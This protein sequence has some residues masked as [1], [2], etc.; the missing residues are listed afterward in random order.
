MKKV[1]QAT[2]LVV[3]LQHMSPK[4]QV[5]PLN[6]PYVVTREK[7]INKDTVSRL[8]MSSNDAVPF[9]SNCVMRF[10]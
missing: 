2:K 10:L 3:S 9:L 6:A 4:N 8:R 1:E 7:A 5:H